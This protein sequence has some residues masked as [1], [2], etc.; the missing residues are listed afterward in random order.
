MAEGSFFVAVPWA[1]A[2][3]DVDIELSD[4]HVRIQNRSNPTERID[5][6]LPASMVPADMETATV[7]F[8]SKKGGGQRED[9]PDVFGAPSHLA[10]DAPDLLGSRRRLYG[11]LG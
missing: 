1:S 8:S 10:G 7:K 5:A 9:A 3:R 11:T 4:S 2:A 6:S